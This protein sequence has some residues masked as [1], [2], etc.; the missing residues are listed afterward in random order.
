MV[1]SAA[2]SSFT[3]SASSCGGPGEQR[4]DALGLLGARSARPPRTRTSAPAPAC[5]R[6]GACGGRSGSPRA[7][8]ALALPS[9]EE[10][11]H[12]VADVALVGG[13]VLLREGRVLAHLHLR[14]QRVDARIGGDRVLVVRGREPPEDQRHRHHVLDAVVAVGGIGERAGLVDDAHARLL[15]LDHDALDLAEALL[16][17]R[18]QRHRRLDG[19]LRVELGREGDLEQHVLHD[20]AAEGLRQRRAA[21]P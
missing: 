13:V 2:M 12:G 20:V 11:L 5:L 17:L 15:R 18:M 21:C 7:R 9:R 16:H 8:A 4:L 6:R 3:G 14:A 10:H 1:T 19:G